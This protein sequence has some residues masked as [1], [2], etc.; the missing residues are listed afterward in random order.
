MT[1]ITCKATGFLVA[2]VGDMTCALGRRIAKTLAP[3]EAVDG[4]ASNQALKDAILIASGAVAGFATVFMGLEDAARL[5]ARS[6]TE[7]TVTLVQHKYGEDASK[8]VGDAMYSVGNFALTANNVTNF[9]VRGIVKRTA[10][11]TGKAMIE[12]YA[13]SEQPDYSGYRV[14]SP[15]GDLREKDGARPGPSGTN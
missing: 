9:G 2:A 8:L 11:E 6:I 15:D 13:R 3:T 12:E 10:K 7:N 5:L 4:V 14:D 1:H